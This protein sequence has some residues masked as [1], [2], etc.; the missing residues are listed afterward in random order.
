MTR[1]AVT[2]SLVTF[3]CAAASVLAA[4]VPPQAV[5]DDTEIFIGGASTAT[6]K[7]NILFI[8]DNSG[9]MSGEIVTQVPFDPA[10]TYTSDDCSADR[11][12]YTTTATVPDCNTDNWFPRTSLKCLAAQNAFN[13]SGFYTGRLAR[14]N[15]SSSTV[16]DRFWT[17]LAQ[18]NGRL[19]ECEADDGIHGRESTS[20]ALNA[21]NGTTDGWGT[22]A[23]IAW[24][25][26]RTYTIYSGNY[27]AW[28][29]NGGGTARQKIDIVREVATNLLNSISGVNVG[30]M[31]FSDQADSDDQGG[32]VAVP[33]ADIE[34]NRATMVAT[35]AGLDAETFTPLSET[36]YEAGLYWRGEIWDYGRTAMKNAG[37][38]ANP[39]ALS[40]RLPADTNRY[41]TPIEYGCQ[42]NYIVYLTDGEP[43]NDSDANTKTAAL[44]GRSCDTTSSTSTTN[45][46]CLDDLAF[47]YANSDLNTAITGAQTVQT[48]TIGFATNQA[49]L[50]RTAARGG[51]KYYNAN[52]TAELASAFQSIVTEILDINTTFS[53]P[54]VSVNAFNR[55][56][57][58]N[59]IYV[60][61][62]RPA[63]TSVWPGNLKKYQIDPVSGELEDANGTPAVNV[64]TGFFKDSS[65]SFWSGTVDGAQA[66]QGGAANRLPLPAARKM[67]T[68]YSGSPTRTL[69]NAANAWSTANAALTTAALGIPAGS[70]N[71]VSQ[72]V[73]WLRGTDVFDVDAD[74]DVAEPRLRMGD[75]LHARP[76]TVIYGGTSAAPDANDGVVYVATN[77]GILQAV[78]VVTGNELWSF[79]PDT[80]WQSVIQVLDDTATST[81]L[82]TLDGSLAVLRIDVDFNGVIEPADGDKVYIYFGQRRGGSNYFALDVTNKASPV[83]LWKATAD[84]LPRIGET[85]S[86][87]QVTKVQVAGSSQS[88]GNDV[89]IFG[90]GYSAGQDTASD[91]T[92]AYTTDTVGNGIYIVDAV[93][94]SLLWRAGGTGS[95]ATLELA[96]MNNAIPG[97]VRAVDFDGDGYSDRLYAGDMGGRVWRFDI[98]HGNSAA[99][100]VAGG[101]FANLGNAQDAT[102]PVAT[103]RRFY[104]APDVALARPRGQAAFLALNIGSGYRA[105]PL[106]EQVE[107]RFYSLRDYGLFTKRTQAEYNAWTPLTD[108]GLL[109]VSTNIAPTL[110]SGSVGWKIALP[111]SGEKVLAEPRTFGNVIYFPTFTPDVSGA[112]ASCT[113]RQGTNRL[114]AVNLFDGSPSNNRDAGVTPVP[115][116][117]ETALAQGG[118]S[119]EAVFLF[120]SPPAGCV[121]EACRPPPR[122]LVGLESCGV[123]FSNAPRKTYWRERQVTP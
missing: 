116:D 13:S 64:D 89:L 46:I 120:P 121:G 113:P 118:I 109:D 42:K 77:E 6:I 18:K 44:I 85:W 54:T 16:A 63:L 20:T 25:V 93:T 17:T 101:V 68:Y 53:S 36:M 71:T 105:S 11:V 39:S 23:A 96:A 4:F 61:V 100:L 34:T 49:L 108:G 97:D 60:T 24:S 37:T 12:Y 45:G 115:A 29:N 102:H 5:A 103:T 50:S 110:P 59:D 88:A 43:T 31:Y 74:G 112:A 98:T 111:R 95:G 79:V 106:N 65:T 58:L 122:C 92:T 84:T 7:P 41:K 99:T 62:F 40:S 107:D 70:T 57:N 9:S 28:S 19:V 21:R 123:E 117:R 10:A 48:Y 81:K 104:Y 72:T 8:F 78:D 27:V 15:S 47:H 119:P 51:G 66:S 91:G 38:V 83:F 55:T 33:V 114:F 22:G 86:T 2:R 87:P 1:Y 76:A 69:T 80:T 35:L 67:Y 14:Y 73:N 32:L 56:Q 52:D 90:G 26:Q 30:L 82:S 3:V 94:G 75:P